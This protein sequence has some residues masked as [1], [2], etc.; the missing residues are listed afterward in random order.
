MTSFTTRNRD[1][2]LEA[3]EEARRTAQGDAEEPAGPA[4]QAKPAASRSSAEFFGALDR[5]AGRV[6]AYVSARLLS[7]LYADPGPD[8]EPDEPPPQPEPAPI[9]LRTDHDSVVD[10][11]HLTPNLTADDL[12]H[13]RRK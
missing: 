11:L 9:P 13:L 2:F 5:M 6:R 10:E 8:P 1:D 3:L 12:K 7:R 4:A